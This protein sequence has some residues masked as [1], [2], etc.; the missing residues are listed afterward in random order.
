M[1]DSEG[2]VK[3]RKSRRGGGR[4]GRRAAGGAPA[5]IV[6]YITRNIPYYEVLDEEGL[7]L[8]E[9]NAET[10][11]EEVGIEFRDD[12]E[13][14]QIWRDAG[15]TVEGELVKFP[16]GMC[17]SIIQASA[18]SEYVH[19]ARN[20]ARNVVVGGKNTAFVPAYGSPFVYDMDKGRRYATIEDFQNFVKLAYMAP[21]LHLSG[22]TIC[23]PVDLPVNKRHFDMLYTHMKY[24]DK[25]FMGSVTAPERAQDSVDM[26]KILFGDD[27]YDENGKPK[28]FM[29]SLINANSPM[30]FDDTM[31][32]AAKVY[33]R[34]NQ[35][36]VVT[37][38]ILAG[39]MSP[40]TVAGTAAQTLAEAMAGMAFVQLVAPGA[41]VV[42]GSFASSISMQSGAPT[43]G[44][45]EPALVLYIM[46]NLA[47]R[48]GVPFRSGGG[49]C[50]SKIPDAQA[51]SEAA[52]TLVPTTL[53]GVNFALH[54]AG[55]LEGGLAMGY[56]KFVMDA[57]QAGMMCTLLKGVDLSENGQALDAIR[58]VGPGN[59]FLGCAHTQANFKTAFY[60]SPLTDNNSF[61]QWES[62][63]SKTMEQRANAYW[64]KQLSEYQAPEIDPAVDQAL[65]DYMERR[66]AEFPDSNI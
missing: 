48:L 28:T 65:I 11:L 43:F 27:F 54:T 21:S 46:A 26:C 17:R 51:A 25:P 23:E 5:E 32:G 3:A 36:C 37:P 12:E 2:P 6:P 45:P 24:S 50:G 47:R 64:K 42:M 59:H 52:N 30:T 19:H 4:A 40:V 8:I 16:K 13:A 61:E 49:F 39:A 44:T 29:T 53:A 34:N 58:E 57:D 35:A 15:A 55:W 1:S 7:A 20:P 63:G 41:P 14:L 60:L 56:E 10:I 22:G 62:E 38:F 31:L 9:A 33:A 66:K 18:P